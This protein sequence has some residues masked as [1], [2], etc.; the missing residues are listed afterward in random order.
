MVSISPKTDHRSQLCH[1]QNFTLC[2]TCVRAIPP[3]VPFYNTS[4]C[5]KVNR[6]CPSCDNVGFPLIHSRGSQPLIARIRRPYTNWI[7]TVFISLL[8]YGVASVVGAVQIMS[9][10]PS[11]SSPWFQREGIKCAG[12]WFK[13]GQKATHSC[14]ELTQTKKKTSRLKRSKL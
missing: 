6:C 11:P 8:L 1:Q 3:L 12:L 7:I 9:H 10:K 14:V 13:S 4:N 5:I 2:H